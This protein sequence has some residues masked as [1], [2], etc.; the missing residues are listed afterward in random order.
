MFVLLR[1]DGRVNIAEFREDLDDSTVRSVEESNGVLK[2]ALT[3]WNELEAE[4]HFTDC[5]HFT[6]PKAMAIDYI[7]QEQ[8]G[9]ILE[10]TLRD[11]LG[12]LNHNHGYSLY[13][14]TNNDDETVCKVVAKDVN[15]V[16]FE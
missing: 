6:E 15:F 16:R 2:V 4:M 5:I 7:Y 11:R 9:E 10:E 12:D 3:L 8:E 1:M 14:L 13:R